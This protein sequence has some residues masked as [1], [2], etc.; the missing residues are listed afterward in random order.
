MDNE[1]SHWETGIDQRHHDLFKVRFHEFGMNSVS[2]P[3]EVTDQ[4]KKSFL[5]VLPILFWIIILLLLLLVYLVSGSLSKNQATFAHL[6]LPLCR[7]KIG[8]ESWYT[9]KKYIIDSAF[10]IFI[11]IL[12]LMLLENHYSVK[13]EKK[14]LK[15]FYLSIAHHGT[16]V[17]LGICPGGSSALRSRR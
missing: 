3:K 13:L 4:S 14:Y 1:V 9:H 17:F 16:F 2:S 8:H 6:Q 12:V 11:I 7:W 5:S 10:Y 15:V